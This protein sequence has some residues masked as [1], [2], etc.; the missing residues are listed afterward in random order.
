[1]RNLSYKLRRLGNPAH[2]REDIGKTYPQ[3]R[4]FL[5]AFSSTLDPAQ[6]QFLTDYCSIPEKGKLGKIATVIRLGVW[7][8]GFS[9]NIAYLMFI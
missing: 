5:Q 1:M 8:T 6:I 4:E 3:A 9:R 2:I 7:K